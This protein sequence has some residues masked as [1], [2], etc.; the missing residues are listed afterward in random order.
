MSHSP[1]RPPQTRGKLLPRLIAAI[2]VL[3]LLGAGW[4]YW[5][6]RDATASEGAYRTVEVERGNIRVVISATGTLS[7]TST[8]TVGSQI[9]G[10]VTDVLVDFNSKVKQGDVL[11]RIDP[12]TYEAQIEQG[13]A[14]IA[15]AQASLAQAQA[16]LLNAELDYRRKVNLGKQQLVAQSD[17]DQAKATYEQATAQVRST[18]A[19]IRQQTASTQTTRVNLQRTVIR[20][21]VDGV[22]LTRSIEPGQTVAA[23]LQAPELFVIAED[24]SKMEIELAVDESDI[25]QVKPEQTVSFSADAFP[26]RQFKGVVDQVRLSAATTNNVVTY[27]VIV[28]VDN[29]DGTLLPG[30]TVNAEIEVS[31]RENV[32]K[33]SNAALRYKP[34]DADQIG[35][36]QRSGPPSGGGMTDE[37]AR[38]AAGMN[39][40]DEQQAAFDTA[41]AAMRERQQAMRERMASSA[42]G[43]NAGG[44]PP[45]MMVIRAGGDANIQAQIRQRMLERFQQDFAGFT[46][47]LDDDQRTQWNQ[48]LSAS[49][50][51]TRATLYRL[52]DGKREAVPVRIGASDGNS[53]EVS[54]DLKEGDEIVSGE[55]APK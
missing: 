54:G 23:S 38:V 24:L 32:L 17:I 39:L 31:N 45:G 48:V 21:P 34:A 42:S 10:Q 50:S 30:L 20:S 12:S 49:L 26:D 6:H 15:A 22:V 1:S 28:S 16:T 19:Q 7:A 43:G 27:P 52:N 40:N 5:S 36:A 33:V 13:N 8:V 2:V 51:A 44:P 4:W 3:A 53:S 25:G 37:L 18:Q 47:L 11:A 55:R 9:S 41:I 46:Q 29:S 35:A 14:Q